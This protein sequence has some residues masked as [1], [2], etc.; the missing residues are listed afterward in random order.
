[1]E[2]VKTRPLVHLI[3][4]IVKQK[5]S[6]TIE[7]LYHVGVHHLVVVLCL[8]VTAGLQMSTEKDDEL[9]KP[10]SRKEHKTE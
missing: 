3:A 4:G 2:L 1:M 5:G 6:K 10:R 8:A 7:N 9:P